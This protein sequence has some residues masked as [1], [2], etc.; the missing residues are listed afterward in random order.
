MFSEI[1]AKI[2]ESTVITIYP[3]TSPDGDALGSCFGLKELL[4]HKFPNKEV[5][6][7][8]ENCN[9]NE[10]FFPK[11]DFVEDG[12][13]ANSLACVLDT[14]NT[15]RILDQRYKLAPFIIKIDHHPNVDPFGDIVLVDDTMGATCELITMLGQELY[16][17]E[18]FPKDAAL[19]LYAGLTTD[20]MGFT[21]SS[22]NAHSLEMA[23]FLSRFG[24]NH[25]E[26]NYR[27]T[28]KS[29]PLFRFVSKLREVA[30]FEDEMIYAIVPASLYHEFGITFEEAKNM[31]STFAGIQGIKIWATITEDDQFEKTGVKY[32][33]SLRSR[34]VTINDVATNFHGGGHSVA[35]GAKLHSEEELPLILEQLRGKLV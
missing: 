14:A 16:Q 29:V 17:E 24:I 2:K 20:T 12:V 34:G 30:V 8:G 18:P 22:T 1:I 35:A 7:L 19:Y 13:I 21:T 5:Y 4:I 27:L 25:N 31:V 33:V 6:V 11:F 28:S 9:L 3:H 10:E 23:A 15:E 26:I 32:A